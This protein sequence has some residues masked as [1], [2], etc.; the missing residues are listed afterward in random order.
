MKLPQRILLIII[1][2][3]TF[4]IQ[5]CK[6]S[7]ESD[8]FVPNQ[9]FVDTTWSLDTSLP[10]NINQSIKTIAVIDSFDCT[11]D[12]KLKVNDQLEVNFGEKGCMSSLSPS[13]TITNRVHIKAEVTAI[14]SKGDLLRNGLIPSANGTLLEAGYIIN[15]KL[16]NR[17]KEVYWNSKIPIFITIKNQPIKS[18]MQFYTMQKNGVDTNGIWI[19]NGSLGA[20][21]TSTTSGNTT[22]TS[23]TIGWFGCFKPIPNST[24]LKTRV[25]VSLPIN[26]TNRNTNVFAL[27]DSFKTVQRLLPFSTGKTYFAPNIPLNSALKIVSISY[28]NNSYYVGVKSFVTNAQTSSTL[29]NITPTKFTLQ[30]L[31]VFL[32]NL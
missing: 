29:L 27:F 5:F 6:K 17:G 11:N 2:T 24:S 12:S 15:I 32:S 18:G 22:I 9:S 7:S 19:N 1:L 23:N 25:N 26:F 4:F 8:V 3:A 30:E 31:V 20:V 28:I 10:T 21:S 14:T 13:S 16:S